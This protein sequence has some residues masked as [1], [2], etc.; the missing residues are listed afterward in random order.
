[1]T[2]APSA[3]KLYYFI[4]HVQC[5]LKKKYLVIYKKKKVRFSIASIYGLP[6][7]QDNASLLSLSIHLTTCLGA[8][9]DNLCSVHIA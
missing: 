6:L 1:M 4:P 8:H 2:D 3:A 7:Q 9:A 5:K